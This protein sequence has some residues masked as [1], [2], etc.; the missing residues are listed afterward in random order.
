[1]TEKISE[2]FFYYRSS[3]NFLEGRMGDILKKSISSFVRVQ[4]VHEF[5]QLI[6]LIDLNNILIHIRLSPKQLKNVRRVYREVFRFSKK[7]Q[8]QR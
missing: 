2:N 6:T 4:I 5:V 3:V 7:F 1:M 8:I